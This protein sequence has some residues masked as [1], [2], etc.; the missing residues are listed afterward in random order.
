MCYQHGCIVVAVSSCVAG[1]L[2]C[3]LVSR[4]VR[5]AI[6]LSPR[7][8]RLSN[9]SGMY[10]AS[11]PCHFTLAKNTCTRESECG[12]CTRE[13]ECG[14]FAPVLLQELVSRLRQDQKA[15]PKALQQLEKQRQGL[16]KKL[17]GSARREAGLQRDNEALQVRV[18]GITDNLSVA[19]STHA[20]GQKYSLSQ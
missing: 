7:A 11:P 2:V 15:H 10:L 3:V 9:S 20:H 1:R 14:F 4:A 17:D 8:V 6:Q 19:S 13:S 16:E 18:L 5:P 12:T